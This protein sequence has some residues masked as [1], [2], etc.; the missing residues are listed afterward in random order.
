[1]V[2]DARLEAIWIK[3]ERRGSMVPVASARLVEG[4]GI[5]GNA[6]RVG[7][8]QVTVL[9]A[10]AWA[11]ATAVVGA[12]VDPIERRANLLVRGVAF[13]E[14]V[15]R[16]L[17]VG[18]A[19]IEIRGETRPCRRMDEA[20]SGLRE[21]LDRGWRGGVYGVVLTGGELRTGDPVSW[22][23][24]AVPDWTVPDS[25]VPERA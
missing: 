11:E 18:E 16:V 21:A 10:D 24:A 7:V 6:D 13:A 5:E 4:L 25:T 3:R 22:E 2:E 23:G 1:V 15:G 20:A 19:R 8:R 17:R 14:T 12:P 9:D